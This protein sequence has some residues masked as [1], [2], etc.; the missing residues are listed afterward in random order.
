MATAKYRHLISVCVALGLRRRET[1]I[2]TIFEGMANGGYRK[3]IVHMH[4]QGRDIPTGTFHNYIKDLGFSNED[5]F[6]KFLNSI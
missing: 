3:I 6:Q 1:K 5:D 4:A 2:C